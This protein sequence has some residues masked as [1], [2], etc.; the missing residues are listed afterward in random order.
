V[1]RTNKELCVCCSLALQTALHHVLAC[2]WWPYPCLKAHGSVSCRVL[3][4][5]PACGL[6]LP[7]P[8]LSVTRCSV[9]VVDGPSIWKCVLE[10]QYFGMALHV[11]RR[12][13]SQISIY[14]YRY[15]LGDSPL[16]VTGHKLT[17][18]VSFLSHVMPENVTA[19]CSECD[20]CNSK[21][22]S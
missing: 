15:I 17:I 21:I 12:P 13:P 14:L 10:G 8:L 18:F 19:F 3:F 7:L 1:V 20:E 4:G 22:L 16:Q 9:S 2:S 11:N 5:A 6:P